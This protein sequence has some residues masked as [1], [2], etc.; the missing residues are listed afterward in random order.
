MKKKVLNHSVRCSRVLAIFFVLLSFESLFAG[1]AEAQDLEDFS[2]TLNKT[3][4]KFNE[5]FKAIERQTVFKFTYYKSE[6]NSNDTYVPLKNEQN[7]KQLLDDISQKKRLYFHQINKII[8]V[9]K[10]RHQSTTGMKEQ[11]I[12]SGTITDAEGVPMPGVTV[13]LKDTD[14]GTSTDFDGNFQL[15]AATGDL[16]VFSY[17]GYI[18]QEITITGSTALTVILEPDISQL[19]EVV[20]V[21]YGVQK[22]ANLTGAVSVVDMEK[23]VADRPLSDAAEALQGAAP[24]L[25]VTS[26][27]GQPGA[28]GLS[29]RIRG[30]ESIN[31]GQ[32]LVLVDNVPMGIND[33]NPRDI[34]T[35]TVLKDVA[36]SS[37]Y[38]ARAAFGVIL[39]T[40]KQG[41][42]EQP[43]SFDYSSNFAF[44]SASNLPVKA[45]PLQHVQALADFGNKNAWTG[46]DIPTWLTLLNAYQQDPGQY[47]EGYAD[48]DGTI[49][50]LA[51]QDHYGK[52]FQNGFEHLHN[53]SFSGG[54]K[55]TSYRVSVGYNDADGIMITDKDS[56]R[57]INLNTFLNTD[58]T[59]NLRGTVN[60]FYKNDYRRTPGN[61]GNIIGRAVNL[62]SFDPTGTGVTPDGEELPYGTSNNILEQEP[63][64]KQYGDNIRLYGKLEYEPLDN[65]KITG[66]Y[67][68]DKSTGNVRETGLRTP[69]I[70]PDT[71]AIDFFN[72][73]TFYRRSSSTTNYHAVNLY[74]NYSRSFGNHNFSILAGTNQESSKYEY[75]NIRRADVINGEVPSISTSTGLASGSD[76][77]SEYAVSGYFGRINYNYREKYLLEMNA[78]YD[79][80]SRFPP[81][82]RFGFFP[83]VSAGWVISKENFME[84]LQNSISLLKLRGSWGE[85]GN[86]VTGSDYPFI[87]GMSPYEAQWID[88]DTNIRYTSLNPP[89][90]VS[91]NFSWETVRSVNL[92]IDIGLFRDRFNG[93]FDIFRR[94]TLD[95]LAPGAELP[96]VVGASAPLQNVADLETKG[97]DLEIS[98]KDQIKS[99]VYSFGFNLSDNR[100]FITQFNNKAGLISD[101]YEGQEIGEL[102][103]YVTDGFYTVDDFV[104]GTLN[105]DLTG[106]VLKEGIPAFEG[107]ETRQ[108]PGDIRFVDLDGDGMITDGDNTLDN[109]GDRKVIGNQGNRRYQFGINGSAS[110][111]NFDLTFFLQGVGKRDRWINTAVFWPYRSQFQEIF[112]NQVDYWTP[113]NTNAYYPRMYPEAGGNTE[114]SRLLQTKYLLN[115]AY[116]RVKN[117]TLGYS[118]PER[119]LKAVNLTKARI[120]FSGENLFTF[121]DLAKGLD[122]E[123]GNITSGGYYPFLRKISF[124]LN[125]SF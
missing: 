117:I 23:Q 19:S 109:P 51:D 15:E 40:T 24:G 36:A 62:S 104:E 16:L 48:I 20:V 115:G 116:L 72:D 54:S 80:S 96:A 55:R 123:A 8:A 41:K 111:K 37:I 35:V 46:Q 65:L 107:Y 85:V 18:T 12:I 67:T 9:S 33:I 30:Y 105:E 10:T 26:D 75:F 59:D 14:R 32:P 100:T 102:W 98:W 84:S 29:M 1:K 22:K 61:F 92:G 5:L 17:I 42:R 50:P 89:S 3:E 94:K 34:E 25:Q 76:D 82:H 27:S 49:Y 63:P 119:F 71:H 78:R 79:G 81:G 103:G 44:T 124:G 87:P 106:G 60:V 95:M 21:G 110:Y 43:I 113:E 53:L 118:L 69:Y 45:S 57:K 31:G 101:Y 74:A 93:S 39:I 88:P 120:F 38:G 108:N 114:I 121:D 91:N 122:A 2:V 28:Q 66:E 52:F 11:R 73:E 90:L 64:V 112:A 99:F 125:I 7:L 97:W 68:F 47:P 86:Q 83:S 4:Y 56:Y 58:L 77:F 6:I 70:A 13:V